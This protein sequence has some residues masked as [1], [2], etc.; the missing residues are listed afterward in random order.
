MSSSNGEGSA[1]GK[2]YAQSEGSPPK[3]LLV[4]DD[5]EM[6]SMLADY[7]RAEGFVTDA[8][9]NGEDAVSAALTGGYVAVILDI[10]L[11]RLSGIEALRQ[12]R[13][14]SDIPVLMLTAKG[15][16]IDRVVGLE[17]GAD[18]YVSKP[19]FPR[20][21]VARLRAV[22]RRDGLRHAGTARS[23]LTLA[24]LRIDTGACW[25]HCRERELEL[26][27][28]EFKLLTA[29]LRA[30]DTVVSKD[31]LSQQVLGRP[32]TAYDR[33]IDVHVSNLRQKLIAAGS[34]VAIE[35]VRGVGYR[36]GRVER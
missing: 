13:R 26:T 15:D 36:V 14:S 25:A 7:L 34:S 5:V 17:L 19:Y 6:T 32:H 33:S 31:E 2:A 3:V 28:S 22:L 16:D 30:A 29:L 35:T 10:M 21:L 23:R 4:D 20:E 18:D 1:R 12:I 27:T 9:Y 24:D 11:P 8:V